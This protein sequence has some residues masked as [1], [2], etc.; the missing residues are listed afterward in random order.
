MKKIFGRP[1][2]LTDFPYPY[3]PGCGHGIVQRL[4][5][6]AMDQ[7]GI[8][9][10]SIGVTSAGCSVRNWKQYACDMTMGLHGRGPA[11]ATGLKRTAP[12]CIIFTYQGDGDMAAIGTGEIIHAAS[13]CER[14][15]VI[16]VNNA[17]FGA[18]GGQQAPTTLLGQ[19]TTSFPGGRDPRT[20]GYPLRMAEVLAQVSPES[21]IARVSIHDVKNI[22]Q[23][24]K[25][26]RRAFEVQMN[27]EGFSLVEYLSMCPTQWKVNP[28]QGLKWVKE[29]MVPYYPLGE[30]GT[31]KGN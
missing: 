23:A 21:Y 19:K 26:T 20:G 9:G 22:N 15:T 3:C 24:A 6:E 30:F 5:G 14:I 10:R 11:V 12:G 7:L 17:V 25:A 8:V 28:A 29:K 18:T 4:V 1:E 31:I 13:R 27:N 16:Y 2:S